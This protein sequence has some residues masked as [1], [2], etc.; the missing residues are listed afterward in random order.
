MRRSAIS[1]CGAGKSRRKVVKRSTTLA[2]NYYSTPAKRAN[3]PFSLSPSLLFP[4]AKSCPHTHTVAP[5]RHRTSLVSTTALA[6]K[7]ARVPLVSSLRV[8]SPP[9]VNSEALP[10]PASLITGVNLLNS[11]SVAIKFV[12][13]FSSFRPRSSFLTLTRYIWTL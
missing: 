6:R 5:V 1:A 9:Y 13:S 4:P 12:R 8:S 10:D 11:Q 7:S 2:L 3:I